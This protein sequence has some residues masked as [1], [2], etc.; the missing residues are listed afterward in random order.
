MLKYFDGL[1]QDCSNS[2]ALATE[3]LQFCIK[4]PIYILN[5]NFLCFDV[6]ILYSINICT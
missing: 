1:V 4:P 5:F 3:L 2:S 6:E